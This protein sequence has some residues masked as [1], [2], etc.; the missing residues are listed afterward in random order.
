MRPAVTRSVRGVVNRFFWL[1]SVRRRTDDKR[2]TTHK[3]VAVSSRSH[4]PFLLPPT[5][6]S[7]PRATPASR[8]ASTH[9]H[10]PAR[11][12][13]PPPAS[14]TNRP[15]AP[16]HLT[17]TLASRYCQLG[18]K[19][20]WPVRPYAGR[21]LSRDGTRYL[22]GSICEGSA[23]IRPVH[24]CDV[25]GSWNVQRRYVVRGS[26]FLLAKHYTETRTLSQSNF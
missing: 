24:R 7:P 6:T 8:A 2:A 25:L 9:P 3:E 23:G 13:L 1:G 22:L 10:P 16:L 19:D 26:N 18:K 12:P 4:P 20:L 14:V 11:A 5:P 17:Q 21:R 15:K